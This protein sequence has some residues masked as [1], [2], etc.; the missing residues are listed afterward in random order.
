MYSPGLHLDIKTPVSLSTAKRIIVAPPSAG[1]YLNSSVLVEHYVFSFIR[2]GRAIQMISNDGRASAG[3]DYLPGEG[4]LQALERASQMKYILK[5][6]SLPLAGR[7][8]AEEFGIEVNSLEKTY[9]ID[10]HK[11]NG[12]LTSKGV[13]PC[14]ILYVD[15]G[16]DASEQGSDRSVHVTV[17]AVNGKLLH[18]DDWEGTSM[19]GRPQVLKLRELA[20]ITDQEFNAYTLVQRKDLVIRFTT[21]IPTNI[22]DFLTKENVDVQTTN[23]LGWK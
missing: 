8:F 5:S 17:S 2:D 4:W 21:G 14:P 7:N 9:P 20:K 3:I 16:V 6:N 12:M 13:V 19:S 1:Y 15:W 10:L 18:I 11:N 23:H 22:L